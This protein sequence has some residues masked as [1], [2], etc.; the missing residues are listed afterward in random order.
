MKIAGLISLCHGGWEE[1]VHSDLNHHD[2]RLLD[3]VFEHIGEDEVLVADRAFGSYEA[4]ARS[5]SQKSW[6][7]SRLHHMRKADFRRGTRLGKDDRLVTWKKP[8]QPK[9]SGISRE[10]WDALPEEMQIRLLRFKTR[11][12]DG[13]IKTII[14]STN[15]TE[16]PRYP[17]ESIASLYHDR[18]EIELRLR[19]L[20]TAMGMEMLRTKT[21]EMARKELA[22]YVI[23]YNVLRLLMLRAGEKH[24]QSPWAISF[25]ATL[26]VVMTWREQFRQLHH[27]PGKRA[28]LLNL[29]LLQIAERKVRK[30]PGRHEPR[31]VK[32]RPKG[33][34]LLT[35]K[36]SEYTEIFHRS[37]YRK[38]A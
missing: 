9:R 31:A 21:P 26:Q 23:A 34:P 37:S 18:W 4:F 15:L 35:E 17:K 3:Q 8:S 32:R 27:K 29:L 20:K 36:R 16:P 14:L 33:Y 38:L 12:R 11:G 1:F 25:K 7:V 10:E 24:Q 22:M 6:M 28:E 30:R 2:A 13:K 5:L 19:D